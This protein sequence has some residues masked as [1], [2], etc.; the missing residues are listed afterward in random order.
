MTLEPA[1]RDL[2]EDFAAL[3]LAVQRASPPSHAFGRAKTT[4]VDQEEAARE[5]EEVLSALGLSEHSRALRADGVMDVEDLR[6]LTDAE[7]DSLMPT[8]PAEVRNRWVA[9]RAIDTIDGG[10]S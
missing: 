6:G 10:Q 1:R 8:M 3:S 5:F 2:Q 7:A 9:W 4:G